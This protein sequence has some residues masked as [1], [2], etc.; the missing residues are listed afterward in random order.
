MFLDG[1]LYLG[2]GYTGSSRTDPV[3]HAYDLAAGKWKQLPPC[4]L[5]WSTVT[6]LGG[7]LVLVGGRLMQGAKLATYTN[8]VVVWNMETKEWEFPLPCMA[9]S[10]MCPV[11]IS[12]DDYLIAAGG[13]RGALDFAAEVLDEKTGKWVTGSALPLPCISN[14]SAVVGED[15]YL[16]NMANDVIL[17]A[18]IR[19]YIAVATRPRGTPAPPNHTLWRR[20]ESDPPAIPFKIVSTNSQLLAFSDP[21]LVCVTAHVYQRDV[22]VK[23]VGRFPSTASSALFL[24]S[25]SENNVLYVLG[26]EVSQQYSN[27]AHKLSFMTCKNLK[28]IK[29][30][31][32]ARLSE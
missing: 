26:G 18:N 4:P 22:W 16:A 15:W 6:T 1:T 28:V 31:R 29:K 30:S 11:V 7:K 20:L 32:Q 21:H 9:V 3:V 5:K 10:R 12:L 23:V 17:R 8:K 19:E 24:E 27:Q 14:M 13:K 25:D 2:G